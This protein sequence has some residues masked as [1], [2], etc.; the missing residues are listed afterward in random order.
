MGN[1]EGLIKVMVLAI[2]FVLMMVPVQARE[3]PVSYG[4]IEFPFGNESFADEVVGFNPGSGTG[5][6]DG[7]AAA[8][9][10][11]PDGD[12]NTGPSAIGAKGDVT[13]GSGGSIT[14]KFTDNYLIDVEGLDLY[15]FEYGP[16]VES[17]KVEISKDGSGWIDLGTISGQPTGL[18]IHG[19]V[20]LGDRFSYV[21]ITDANPYAPRDPEKIGQTLYVGAD[22]DA[23][24]AIGTEE[25]PDLDGDGVPDDIDECPGTP[26]GVA[27][28]D[29]GCPIG[30]Q[31]SV[32][33][34]KMTY[35]PGET[36]IIQ[37]SVWDANGGL[38]GAT[39]AIDVNGT[40][41][42]TTAYSTEKYMGKY[43]CEFPLPSGITQGNY[44]VTATA[45]YS[46]YP[47]ISESTSF[48]V[49]KMGI[50]PECELQ[51]LY[52][53]ADGDVYAYSYRNWNWANWGMYNT[54]GAG[55]HPVGG[56]KRA[57]LRFDLP[58]GLDIS[59]AVLKLYQYHSAGPVHTLGVYRVTSPWEEGTDTYHSGEAEEK[60]APGELCWMQQPS[61]DPVPVATFTSAA[62]VPAWVEV[63]ITSLVAQWQ[64]GTPNYGLVVKT[65]NE[66]PT[67]SDPEARSGFFTKEHLDQAN[68]PVLELSLRQQTQQSKISDLRGTLNTDS[69]CNLYVAD[70]GDNQVKKINPDGSATPY[71]SGIDRP[72]YQVFDSVGNLYVGS[73]DG[74][75]YKVS[76]SGVKTV[77]ASGIWSPQ[78]MGFDSA[79]NL[80]VAGGYDGKIHRI[81]PDGS[82]TAMD[83]GFTYPKHLAVKTDGNVYVV[84]NSGTSILRITPEGGKANLVDLN[85]TILG[86]ATDGEYLYVSHS[87]KISRIDSFGQVTHIATDLDQPSS[88]TV[89]SGN[90]FVT[91]R[92]GIVKA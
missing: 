92:D 44:T 9:I 47:S 6:S 33:T 2:V 16:A 25:R 3:G 19:K 73:F 51:R 45:S 50:T 69:D 4:G 78:G 54:M 34:D 21:R 89:C 79:G 7:S 63:D 76:A 67:A 83:S 42:T 66:H 58:A 72:R 40:K 80:Y 29:R 37:G 82:K 20:A 18:D 8:A 24:G 74:N 27:V 59:R 14:I 81:A 32:S 28:D 41:L 62:A 31:L 12:K 65:T 1:N 17:F 46:G 64:G 68:R 75:I 13:L 88:L 10:G 87:D 71:T 23:V 84:G 5:E 22:I 39:V 61:F 90:V 70:Y 52:P 49:E 77:V 91:V 36:V 11:P 38:D 86:M 53:V 55:W 26:A 30:M 15:V 43:E 57:Y 56:E 48:A 85:E 60:A 35:S